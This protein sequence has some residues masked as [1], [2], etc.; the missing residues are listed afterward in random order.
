[1]GQRLPALEGIVY[2]HRR[3]IK[4]WGR[5]RIVTDDAALIERLMP[6]D[7]SAKPEQVIIFDI[8]AWDSNCPQHI[9][10]KIDA[11]DVAETVSRLEAWI[12]ALETENAALK[13][14]T[15]RSHL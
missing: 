8:E 4:I 3:R 11:A 9:P 2:A 14:K 1:L 13:A 7:Y 15:E 10:Q 12:A 5:A 6:E